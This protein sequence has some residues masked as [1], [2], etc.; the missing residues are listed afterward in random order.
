VWD[1]LRT[2]TTGERLPSS[3]EGLIH[4]IATMELSQG[5]SMAEDTKTVSGV[6]A[7]SLPAA[8]A[9]GM[10]AIGALLIS[11]QVQ[12]ARIE[13]TLVQ[14]AKSVE[15]LKIDARTQLAELDR[16]V[17]TLEMRD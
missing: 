2:T 14:M 7:A 4:S 5:A 17:R 9:A 13:A 16:R 12:S 8:L 11:M 15:E 10:V 1:K 6:F 3:P